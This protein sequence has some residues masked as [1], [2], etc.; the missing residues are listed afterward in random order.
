MAEAAK[1]IQGR[2]AVD[3]RG[4]VGFVNDFDFS[5]VKRFYS[6]EN[7]RQGFVRAW[8]GHKRE[9]K[10]CTV[11]QGAMLVCCIDIDDWANPSLDLPV[12]RYVLSERNPA[13]LSI[14]AG[15]VNGFMSLTANAKII[16]FSTATLQES[17][18]DDIR[19]P[20]RRW[21]PWRV[22]ER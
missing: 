22:E 20:A 12:H 11:V 9:S 21:D 1:L 8:H 3:D 19:F 13:V 10:H 14:P 18:Q 6:V 2:A 4:A 5:G 15:H 17:E 16:F 7:H